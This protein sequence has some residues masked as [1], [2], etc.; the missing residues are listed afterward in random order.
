MRKIIITA[1]VH[2]RLTINTLFYLKPR[3]IIHMIWFYLKRRLVRINMYID[4]NML[5]KE[6]NKINDQMD[7]SLCIFLLNKKQKYDKHAI[8]WID[9]KQEKLWRYH[10]NSFD[11]LLKRDR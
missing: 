7:N 10:L 8:G 9:P 11:I 2:F 4:K 1:I 6:I 5:L 3:Q